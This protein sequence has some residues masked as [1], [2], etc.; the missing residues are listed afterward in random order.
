MSPTNVIMISAMYENGGNTTHRFLDGH[1]GLFVYPFESQ[2]GTGYANDFLTSYVPIRYR[3]PEF[4]LIGKAEEDYES[5]W[6]EEL[7][8]FLRAPSRSKF[9]DCGIVM[10]ELKRRA[11]FIELVNAS[12][13]SRASIVSAFF[14]STFDCW[15]NYNVSGQ[16]KYYVGYNPIQILD[17]DKIL[18]DFPNGH[19][20]HVVRNPY[21]GY[22][23]QFRRPFPPTLERYGHTW[24]YCQFLALTYKTKY[25]KNVHIIRLE[26]L[27]EDRYK[28]ISNLLSAI[29]LEMSDKC[30]NPSFNG[31]VLE[32]IAPWGTI[33]TATQEENLATACEL[34]NE[35]K[36]GI[37]NLTSL[38]QSLMGY[39]NFLESGKI[40][41][42]V[43]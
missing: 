31:R 9:R 34:N 26:D 3:W 38:A 36:Q 19:V 42:L 8:T 4:P 40:Q 21:S 27:I 37:W 16:E 41:P 29:G 11:R 32:K 43:L 5:F 14:R 23:D 10:N 6:D 13:R 30:L 24:A 35:Q 22:A 1:P 12:P 25:P 2:V 18:S 17:T 7:K 20:I 39:D 15:E 28:T 33:R